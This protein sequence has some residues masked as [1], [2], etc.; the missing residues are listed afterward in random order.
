MRT[1]ILLTVLVAACGS[2]AEP[3]RAPS[4]VAPVAAAE[5]ARAT[6]E[7]TSLFQ[8]EMALEDQAAQP[9][10]LS[11]LQGHPV[12]LAFFYTHCETMCPTI[13]SDV[14]RIEAELSPA[15]RSALRVV[16]VSF[17]G[18]R[19]TASR[20]ATVASERGI[21]LDR[22]T[23]VR[24]ADADVR[25]LAATLGM[26]Y[27]RTSDGEF[28]HAALFTLLDGEGR[29]ALTVDGTGRDE[30]LLRAAIERLVVVPN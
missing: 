19:D 8:L 18:E 16:L 28:A 12:L 17:D 11:R 25:T 10:S 2:T 6:T 1:R 5:P 13:I 26:T 4:A 7:D 24:G 22:W 9:F 30:A 23:L 14:R 29:V 21:E 27:R 20:L 15:A 3:E